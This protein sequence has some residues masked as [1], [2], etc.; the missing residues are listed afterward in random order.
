M[1]VQEFCSWW[2]AGGGEAHIAAQIATLTAPSPSLPGYPLSDPSNFIVFPTNVGPSESG[3]WY[4]EAV[5]VKKML[6]GK[7]SDGSPVKI[8]LADECKPV[9]GLA[10]PNVATPAET[11][12]VSWLQDARNGVFNCGELFTPLGD[13][14]T[15]NGMF[16]NWPLVTGSI[17][18]AGLKHYYIQTWQTPFRGRALFVNKAFF[19]GRSGAEQEMIRSAAAKCHMQNLSYLSQGQDIIVKQFQALGGVIH[20]R[21]PNDYLTTLR[22]ATDEI[23]RQKATTDPVYYGATLAHQRAFIRANRVRWQSGN[24]DRTWRFKGRPNLG[25]IAPNYIGSYDSDLHPDTW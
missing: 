11:P 12:S 7:W 19:L 16:P 15:I 1:E 10:F 2:Y 21:L 6:D 17:I 18:D 14:S 9:H 23:Y 3:G 13:S 20:E 8:R 4:K 5:T 22:S 24:L 25:T